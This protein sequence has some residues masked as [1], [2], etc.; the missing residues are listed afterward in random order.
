[1]V[2]GV[3]ERDLTDFRESFFSRFILARRSCRFADS[4]LSEPV[5]L[6]VRCFFCLWR[7]TVDKALLRMGGRK[8]GCTGRGSRRTVRTSDMLRKDG[9]NWPLRKTSSRRIGLNLDRASTS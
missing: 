4:F 5:V 2:D 6:T 1:V 3:G 7:T 8:D 9:S